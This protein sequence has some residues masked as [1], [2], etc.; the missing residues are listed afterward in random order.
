VRTHATAALL[1]LARHRY[2]LVL[3]AK[4][5]L[6]PLVTVLVREVIAD[7]NANAATLP[8][9]GGR[10]YRYRRTA[11]WGRAA[12]THCPGGSQTTRGLGAVNHPRNRAVQNPVNNINH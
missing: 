1:V 12:A 6:E 9:N 11:A 7:C 10:L 4:S 3:A 2:Y 5:R 8:E